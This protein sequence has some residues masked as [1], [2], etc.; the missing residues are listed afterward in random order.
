VTE[1]TA[2]DGGRTATGRSGGLRLRR[3]GMAD[4]PLLA[5]LAGPDA[6]PGE[7]GRSVLDDCL[8]FGGALWFEAAGQPVSLLSWREVRGGWELRPVRVA[9]GHDGFSHSRWL[10]T[11]VEALAIRMNVPRL[12]LTLSEPADLEL[13]RRMGYEPE[14]RSTRRL[15]RRVG[16][17]WQ[18]R[19]GNA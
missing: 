14:D 7:D 2:R 16:G 18:L 3:A 17:T 10:M 15:V 9:D 1:S 13:Y 11:Q 19:R 5:E 4:A 12:V 6:V 8:E